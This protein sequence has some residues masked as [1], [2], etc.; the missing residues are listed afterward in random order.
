MR[1]IFIILLTSTL[2]FFVVSLIHFSFLFPS[3]R[4]ISGER[5]KIM[6]LSPQTQNNFFLVLFLLLLPRSDLQTHFVNYLLKNCA[7]ITWKCAILKTYSSL[8]ENVQGRILWVNELC[9]NV[10]MSTH[11]LRALTH[12]SEQCNLESASI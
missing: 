11:Q 7:K 3:F 4:F 5:K 1:A 12:F 9:F 6:R 8:D 10:T 2:F